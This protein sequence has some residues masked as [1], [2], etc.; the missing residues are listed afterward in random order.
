M[1]DLVKTPMSYK[2][3]YMAL[4]YYKEGQ[5]YHGIVTNPQGDGL[6]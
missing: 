2:G 3:S 5:S 1:L 6:Y 4:A